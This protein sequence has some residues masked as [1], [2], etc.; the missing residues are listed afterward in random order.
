MVA[1]WTSV[2]VLKLLYT[3]SNTSTQPAVED[4]VIQWLFRTWWICIPLALQAI[5]TNMFFCDNNGFWNPSINGNFWVK[6]FCAALMCMSVNISDD[7]SQSL[8]PY[9][10]NLGYG[11]RNVDRYLQ[12]AINRCYCELQLRNA[13]YSHYESAVSYF[14]IY[15][16]RA[17]IRQIQA[18]YF[19]SSL[20]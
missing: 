8:C 7:G 20:Q 2:S 10:P 11:S 1:N 14:T 4:D 12:F 3:L 9:R 16:V 5:G 15:T 6:T 13:F 17:S 19:T 18:D